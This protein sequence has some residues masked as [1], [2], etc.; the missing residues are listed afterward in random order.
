MTA[1]GREARDDAP[2][3]VLHPWNQMNLALLWLA[4]MKELRAPAQE[5]S[6]AC[7]APLNAK[8]FSSGVR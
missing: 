4:V 6:A 8:I 5:W 7:C 3:P 2:L 1:R